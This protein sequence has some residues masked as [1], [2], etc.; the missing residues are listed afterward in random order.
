MI[1]N[2]IYREKFDRLKQKFGCSEE[3]LEIL[4]RESRRNSNNR[5]TSVEALIDQQLSEVDAPRI[6][7]IYAVDRSADEPTYRRGRKPKQE[8]SGR[9][10]SREIREIFEDIHPKDIFFMRN[11]SPKNFK[12][13]SVKNR[14][15]NR[16]RRFRRRLARRVKSPNDRLNN[17][18]RAI[19][20]H[21]SREAVR[22][23]KRVV[24]SEAHRHLRRVLGI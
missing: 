18:I 22:E 2:P 12:R 24:R 7:R 10:S 6:R 8:E 11:S 19:G 13:L 9:L 17:A 3:E 14:I 23:T 15:E 4:L 1:L 20:R 5:L 16:M 21:G